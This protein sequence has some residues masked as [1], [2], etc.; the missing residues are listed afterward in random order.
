MMVPARAR[1]SRS[2][3]ARK[4]PGGV[5]AGQRQKAVCFVGRSHVASCNEG[6]GDEEASRGNLKRRG[7]AVARMTGMTRCAPSLYSSRVFG[8][9]IASI[10]QRGVKGTSWS[11]VVIRSNSPLA[12]ST[13][14]CVAAS[15]TTRRVRTC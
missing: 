12:S 14:S 1:G 6:G 15:I 8:C 7:N 11:G 10:M 3:G 13:C 5:A 9:P 4:H 2:Y